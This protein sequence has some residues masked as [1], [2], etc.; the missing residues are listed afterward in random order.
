MAL[1]GGY[2]RWMAREGMSLA[3]VL[4]PPPQQGDSNLGWTPVGSELARPPGTRR[5]APAGLSPLCLCTTQR[6]VSVQHRNCYCFTQEHNVSGQKWAK[7]QKLQ[8]MGRRGIV[9]RFAGMGEHPTGLPEPLGL[10]PA[11]KTGKKNGAPPGGP[12]PPAGGS[13]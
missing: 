1:L 6:F 11:P 12:G 9:M 7:H 10:F 4:F 2:L 5:P 13:P 8:E 3:D